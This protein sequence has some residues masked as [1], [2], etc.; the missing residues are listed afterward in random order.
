[1]STRCTHGTDVSGSRPF[2]YYISRGRQV[3]F[4]ALRGKSLLSYGRRIPARPLSPLD[5]SL[6]S[7]CC[8]LKCSLPNSLLPLYDCSWKSLHV[9]HGGKP[10]LLAPLG[11]LDLLYFMTV[12]LSLYH[13]LALA[14][15]MDLSLSPFEQDF[16]LEDLRCLVS[17]LCLW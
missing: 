7:R 17:N 12:S 14:I 4:Y 3:S 6:L 11:T 13:L 15:A 9:P 8:P 1:M 5:V 16:T 10:V 2:I